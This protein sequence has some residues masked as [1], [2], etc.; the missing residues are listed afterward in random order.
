MENMV[1]VYVADKN[2]MGYVHISA[3][4]LL[5]HNPSAHIVVVS[6]EPVKTIY[7]N[8][9]IPLTG[10]FRH[11]AHDRITDTTYLKLFLTK[12]PFEKI[13]YMDGDTIVQK[14]LN[15]LWAINPKYIALCESHD[16]GKK[17]AEELGVKKYGITGV[18]VMNLANLRKI[19]FTNRCLWANPQVKL[20]CHEETLINDVM[21]GALKFIP[22]K[23]NYCHNREYS[24]RTI[25]LTE[26]A[27][28][29]ICGRD[30][31]YMTATPYLELKYVKEYIQDKTVAIVGNAKSLFDQ[32]Y[33]QEIDGHDV[34]IRFNRGFV[35]KPESQG[36]KT[37]IVFLATELTVDEK[38]TYKAMFYINRSANTKCGNITINNLDRAKL[39]N[40][41]GAQPSTG[42][43]AIDI[44]RQ[45]EAKSIDLYGFD[46]EATPTFYNPEG[47]QTKHNYAK[48]KELVSAMEDVRIN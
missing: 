16:F 19:D 17:Q 14:P 10:T 2:Y 47:Y 26:V 33:G 4:T 20:W 32:H 8:F 40:K 18:M 9:V 36:T 3:R 15:E 21:R 31:S 46:F 44:C 12:L 11:R 13:I 30:K 38:L 45:A 48:E 25:P 29:H 6:P 1:V 35:T 28:L 7:E 27:I 43:M 5:E 34:I 23:W 24:D 37:D 41:I 22:V 39:K 42:F